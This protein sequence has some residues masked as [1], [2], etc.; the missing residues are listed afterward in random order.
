MR[1]R[2]LIS[3][4]LLG[5]AFGMGAVLPVQVPAAPP[6]AQQSPGQSAATSPE[7]IKT[8]SQMV[9][10]DVI[11]TDKKDHHLTD[12]AAKDFRVYED[13]KEQ[14]IASFSRVTEAADSTSANNR[15]YL[16]LF[17]DNST[18]NASDQILARK[19]AAEFVA[20]SASKDREM[21][22]IDFTGV[23]RVAQ[24]FTSDS[25]ALRSAVE[26]VKFGML[27][28]NE[29]GQSTDIAS[30]GGPFPVQIRS[31]FAARSVLIA[32]RNM[33]R[34]LRSIPGRKTMILFTGGF[35]LNV[36]REEELSATIDSANKANVAI[37]PVDVRG[38]QG[39]PSPMMN[40]P[41]GLR[42]IPGGPPGAY[43]E[44][45]PFPHEPALLASLE[46]GIQL[47]LR[48]AQRPGGGGGGTSGGGAGGGAGPRGGGGGAGGGAIGGGGGVPRG[49]GTGGTGGGPSGGGG[50]RGGA[51]GPVGGGARG[52]ASNP[53]G[54]GQPNLRNMPGNQIIPPLM[55]SASTN[56]Q[57]L[58]A[59]AGGTGGFVIVN[60]DDFKAGL[61]K[62]AQDMDDYYILG[63]VPPNPLHD[64]SY[65]RIKVKV[66]RH[67][68]EIR[69]RNGYFD[70][71]SADL[72]AGKPEGKVLE[73]QAARSAPGDFPVSLTAPFFY[74]SPGVARVNLAIEMPSSSIAFDKQ[75]GKFHS[76]ID[77]LGIAY[78]PDGSV[79]ARFSDTVKNDVEK[80][81][82][83][84]LLKTP[85]TYQNSFDIAPG[86]YDLKIVMSAGEDK[87]GK[88]E[89]PLSIDS[90]TGTQFG[91]SDVALSR[92]M[93]STSQLTASLDTALLEERTPLIVKGL[94]IIPT[95]DHRFTKQEKITLYCE[96]YEPDRIVNDLPR[97]GIIE[98][99]FNRQTKQ[100]VW[101]SNTILVN[102][103]ALEGNPVI[104]VALFVPV[105][106]L[107]AG[108][109]RLEVHAL[110][111]N[112]HKSPTRS[113]DLVLN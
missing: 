111:S 94:E 48:F 53:N 68:V 30:M 41:G 70:V 105:D 73:E 20:Q 85:F 82:M 18:M 106:S 95:P 1:R 9:L 21:A 63:Y 31:D 26:G 27:Q 108:E 49:G 32:L 74:T 61:D 17:F 90:F 86:K 102:D 54:F 101:T 46:G 110:D 37:Y 42:Q 38:L 4:F 71:K 91:I 12:L 66:E 83:K 97:V 28:P 34:S 57:V 2:I 36:E 8:E 62:I 56:Q 64:G 98:D 113:T 50:T 44:D 10:V 24:N 60:T 88:F 107:Q 22:V 43:L 93:R 80:K 103:F 16:V 19:A 79:A 72:L 87:F 58:Y 11:A 100:R 89:T 45:S 77:V 92:E 52:G 104:P 29:A 84:E 112:G 47:P 33:C 6:G 3:I 7:V 67:G 5:L 51:P 109:Y 25:S 99:L 14:P 15:R 55:E 96:V 40:N 23:T 35:P 59:L 39:L 76:E 69:A 75:K 65:H 13:D 78:R 81:E